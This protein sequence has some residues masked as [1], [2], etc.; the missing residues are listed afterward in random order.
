MSSMPIRVLPLPT[1]SSTRIVL[2]L[3]I[4]PKR[5]ASRPSMTV[6]TNSFATI[7]HLLSHNPLEPLTAT[8]QTADLRR[9]AP[10]YSQFA[11]GRLLRLFAMQVRKISCAPIGYLTQGW[12]GLATRA[13]VDPLPHYEPFAATGLGDRSSSAKLAIVRL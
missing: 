12:R 5:M 3:G 7:L 11:R 2:L 9:L 4:P 6:L 10:A 1:K 8:L 13:H